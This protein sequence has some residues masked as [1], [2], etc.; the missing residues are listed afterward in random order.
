[1]A[2]DATIYGLVFFAP[3]LPIRTGDEVKIVWRMTGR[4]DLSVTYESPDGDPATLTFGPEPHS[5]STYD[6]PG[7]EWGTGFRFDEPGC[8]HIHLQRTEG[9]GDV[10]ITV[11]N[12]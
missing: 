10:W 1:M 12:R 9:S 11:A 6:R 2:T 7:D 5:G 8:W 3:P 4:G